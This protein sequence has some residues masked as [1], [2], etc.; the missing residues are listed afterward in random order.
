M[1]WVGLPRFN[2]K[3]G[4]WVSG[5]F[6][7]TL[8]EAHRGLLTEGLV[9]TMRVIPPLDKPDDRSTRPVMVPFNPARESSA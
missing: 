5:R 1:L 4:A 9:T 7:V 3:L 6:L 8:F 2:E